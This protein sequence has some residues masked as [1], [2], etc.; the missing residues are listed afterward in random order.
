M[1]AC[2]IGL[3]AIGGFVAHRLIEGGRDVCALA[4]GATLAAVRTQ[5]LRLRD[6]PAA[7]RAADECATDER[8]VP[9]AASDDPSALGIQDLVIV[10][11]KTTALADLPALIA[12]LLGPHTLVVS[13]MNGVPWWFFEGLPEPWRGMPLRSADPQGLLAA[14]IAPQRVVG[15]VVHMSAACPAPGRVHQAFGERIILGE[16]GGVDAARRASVAEFFTVPGLQIEAT[17]RIEEALWLKLWGNLTMNPVSAL[18]GATMDRI[19]DDPL[20]NQFVCDAMREA[21]AIGE[22][23]GVPITMTPDARNAITRKLGAVRTSMLQDVDAK[24]PIE[25]DALVATVHEIAQRVQVQTPSINAL[26]GLTRLF[27]AV[28]TERIAAAGLRAAPDPTRP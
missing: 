15:A 27:D 25:L 14:A 28:R 21:A 19:L 24:R 3:G 11:L 1:K 6:A 23:I 2:V 4:R 9:I 18:T 20:L 26:L 8:P 22:R 7:G 17:A 12:P 10:T 13:M 5:G 16:P